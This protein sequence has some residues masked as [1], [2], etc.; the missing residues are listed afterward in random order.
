MNSGH[1]NHSH[2]YLTCDCEGI[3]IKLFKKHECKDNCS[4]NDKY[5]KYFFDNSDSYIIR[6]QCI[7]IASPSEISVLSN[8]D[9]CYE[10]VCLNCH[11]SFKV[12]ASR[13]FARVQ[14]VMS[15][16]RSKQILLSNALPLSNSFP[17][18]LRPYIKICNLSQSTPIFDLNLSSSDDKEIEESYVTQLADDIRPLIPIVGDIPSGFLVL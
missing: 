1:C 12:I 13:K 9:S 7:E 5:S 15:T 16:S 4:S 18:Q 17:F 8:V 10:L 14:Q 2:K 6:P 3:Y 11:C